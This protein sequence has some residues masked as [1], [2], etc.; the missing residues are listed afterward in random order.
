MVCANLFLLDK[1][2]FLILSRWTAERLSYLAFR[3]ILFSKKVRSLLYFSISNETTSS[4][5]I[6]CD[7]F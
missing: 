5:F 7:I 4:A 2:S 6:A 1:I 3:L